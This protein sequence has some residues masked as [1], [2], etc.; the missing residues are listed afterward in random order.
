MKFEHNPKTVRGPKMGGK[1]FGPVTKI[2]LFS[3]C[4]NP[5]DKMAKI[6]I[7]SKYHFYVLSYETKFDF[8]GCIVWG[9]SHLNK[10]SHPPPPP[11]VSL[12]ECSLRLE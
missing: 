4:K 12:L 1:F 11:Q 9:Y 7:D 2:L 8:L 3:P 10:I 6:T 5:F